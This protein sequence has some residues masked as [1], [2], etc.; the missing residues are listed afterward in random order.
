MENIRR[1]IHRLMEAGG[2]ENGKGGGEEQEEERRRRRTFRKRMERWKGM[3]EDMITYK[4]MKTGSN[5]MTKMLW[6]GKRER[7]K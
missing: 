5:E 6:R 7:G 2:K 3:G 4:D 1:K